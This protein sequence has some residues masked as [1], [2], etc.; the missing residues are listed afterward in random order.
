MSIFSS[1]NLKINYSPVFNRLSLVSSD[2]FI[3]LSVYTFSIWLR[4]I[5]NESSFDKISVNQN[6]RIKVKPKTGDNRTFTEVENFDDLA[7]LSS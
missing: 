2:E 5:E 6:G 1:G 3:S 4:M 7:K